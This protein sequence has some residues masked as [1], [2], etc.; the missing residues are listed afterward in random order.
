MTACMVAAALLFG[1]MGWMGQKSTAFAAEST[2][3]MRDIRVS[4]EAGNLQED[5]LSQTPARFGGILKSYL[6]ENEDGTI[7]HITQNSDGAVTIDTYSSSYEYLNCITLD[8]ECSLW[9]GYYCG[10]DYNFCL[11]GESN[12][13]ESEDAEV[14]RV[15]KYSKDWKRL[16]AASFYGMN[17][18]IPFASGTPRMCEKNGV[19]YLHMSHQMFRSSDGLNH[20]ANLQLHLDIDSMTEIYSLYNVSNVGQHGY[21]SH[22]FDQYIQSDGEYV[23]T[24]DLGDAYPRS[25]VV[26]KKN[27][28]RQHGK[29]PGCAAHCRYHWEQYNRCYIG[30]FC[31]FFRS[32]CAHW[33]FHA[34]GWFGE[35][36]ECAQYF[37]GLCQS[38]FI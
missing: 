15:V 23:Y 10:K 30:R 20:Q 3:T 22:S 26:C 33:Q 25:V 21:V 24:A 34:A 2:P 29:L 5:V 37:C 1:G 17:T 18:R 28:R 4:V 8:P 31:A 7:S 35:Q 14:L 6:Q 38:G 12:I 27:D 11:Y 19:L 32:G 13:A 9:G 16:D 36:F